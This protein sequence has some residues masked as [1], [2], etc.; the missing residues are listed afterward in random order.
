LLG[1][2]EGFVEGGHGGGE[3]G[4]VVGLPGANGVEPD[5]EQGVDGKL[6]GKAGGGDAGCLQ[7]PSHAAGG[8]GGEKKSGAGVGGQVFQEGEDAQAMRLQGVETA[9]QKV[10]E[11]LADGA[12]GGGVGQSAGIGALAEAHQDG[13]AAGEILA[14]AVQR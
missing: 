7:H 1:T 14:G 8:G 5:A 3:I 12:G 13:V 9:H 10:E 6:A 11:A 2:R 4:G